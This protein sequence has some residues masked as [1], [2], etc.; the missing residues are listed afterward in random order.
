MS[1]CDQQQRP[2][3]TSEDFH[4]AGTSTAN[5]NCRQRWEATFSTH[6]D[7]AHLKTAVKEDGKQ[8]PCVN[9]L[10][11]ICWKAFLLF[12]NLQTAQWPKPLADSRSAYTSMKEHFP[13]PITNAED[14]STAD[15]PLTDNEAVSQLLSPPLSR[16]TML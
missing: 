3:E 13:K 6:S 10:R 1:K 11:S 14:L 8:G 15:D 5:R 12:T 9:G 7:L 4:I 2:S 16:S